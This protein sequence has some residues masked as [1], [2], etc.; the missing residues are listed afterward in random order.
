MLLPH[1]GDLPRG[2]YFFKNSITW[3][4][5]WA[6]SMVDAL[7]R[8]IRPLRPWVPLFH[9]SIASSA[10]SLWCT[11][12]TGPSTRRPSCGS[13]TTTAISMMRSVSGT[14]PVIS[15][16]IQTRFWSLAASGSGVEPSLV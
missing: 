7:T 9:A 4:S 3:A 16:S 5:A 15:R 11:A 2:T 10:A 13:V 6:S 1:I 12:K 14:S 8:S